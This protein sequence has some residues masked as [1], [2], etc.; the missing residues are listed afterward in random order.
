MSEKLALYSSQLCTSFE[1]LVQLAQEQH[2]L[3]APIYVINYIFN[4]CFFNVYMCIFLFKF[5]CT[6]YMQACKKYIC[7]RICT[8]CEMI[9]NLLN[10]SNPSLEEE[11]FEKEN[12]FVYR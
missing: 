8:C 1:M 12:H 3:N 5:L 2:R 9:L 11:A 4:V 7:G 6:L 10:D